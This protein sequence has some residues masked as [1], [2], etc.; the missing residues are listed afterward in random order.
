M[1]ELKFNKFLR[2]ILPG[3]HAY[4]FQDKERARGQY[5]A[6]ML[7]R[8]QSMFKWDGLPENK[9]TGEAGRIIV[10]SRNRLLGVKA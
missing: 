5:I 4:D 9:N 2:E 1:S 8:T 7:M 3:Y 6:Y 10:F